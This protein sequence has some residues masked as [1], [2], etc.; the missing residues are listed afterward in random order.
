MSKL[1]TEDE[2]IANWVGDIEH[3]TVSICC[4]TYNHELYIED[5]LKSFLMQETDFSY[6]ILI[7]DD[8]SPDGTQKIIKKYQKLYPNIVKPMYQKENQF[9]KGGIHPNLEFNYPRASGEYIA[10]CEGDDYWTDTLRLNKQIRFIEAKDRVIG[11]AHN[12]RV[13]N[14]RGNKVSKREAHPYKELSSHIFSLEDA[15]KFKLAGQTS[16]VVYRNIWKEISTEKL[17]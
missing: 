2:I 16:S 3:I 12:V 5:A 6:E 13:I 11:T 10:L 4:I 8:A 17:N 7:H 1:L 9:S 15:E 14:E